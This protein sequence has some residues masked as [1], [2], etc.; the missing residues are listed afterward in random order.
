[1]S[2][3]HGIS[4]DELDTAFVAFAKEGKRRYAQWSQVPQAAKAGGDSAKADLPKAAKMKLECEAKAKDF[5]AQFRPSDEEG[6]PVDPKRMWPSR[7]RRLAARLFVQEKKK[8][9]APWA[10]GK[11]T[12]NLQAL[13]AA[14]MIRRETHERIYGLAVPDK[15]EET[16]EN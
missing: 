7:V 15:E 12:G 13:V 10:P 16:K 2:N 1:M 6:N 5:Y 9:L 4:W 11:L 14:K 3:S 8:F